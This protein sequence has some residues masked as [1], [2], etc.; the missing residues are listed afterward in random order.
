MKIKK[1][2]KIIAVVMLKL[3]FYHREMP[4]KDTDGMECRP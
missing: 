4:Q 1:I 2:Y 3:R